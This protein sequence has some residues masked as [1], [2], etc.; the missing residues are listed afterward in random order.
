[1]LESTDFSESSWTGSGMMEPIYPPAPLTPPAPAPMMDEPGTQRSKPA[2]KRKAA[3]PKAKKKATKKR[4]KAKANRGSK[5]KRRKPAK[6][7]RR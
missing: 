7:R 3:R 6:R 1:M 4:P 2:A 5:A